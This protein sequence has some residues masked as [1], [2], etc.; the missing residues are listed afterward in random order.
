MHKCEKKC[1]AKD[2]KLFDIVAVATEEESA[3]HT[4]Y[5]C[6]HC[7]N[8]RRVKQGEAEVNDVK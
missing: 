2:F 8:D 6:R 4:I 5:L 7:Y 3:A 1:R